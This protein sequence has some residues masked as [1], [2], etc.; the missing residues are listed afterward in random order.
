[1]L[2]LIVAGAA[3]ARPGRLDALCLTLG[4]ISYPLY[5][6]HWQTLLIARSITERLGLG[7]GLPM[8]AALAHALILPFIAYAAARWY[9]APLRRFLTRAPGRP[10]TIRFP[11]AADRR[12]PPAG[13]R[14]GR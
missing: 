6:L 5:V 9:D 7:T 12:R 11:G 1:V 10:T 3:G 2:A 4:L 8:P 13:N 14:W